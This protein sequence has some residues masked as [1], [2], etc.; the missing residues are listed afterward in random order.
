MLD[1]MI[2]CWNNA[3]GSSDYHWSVWQDGRRLEMGG[4]F[5]RA[6]DA[7]SAARAHCQAAF[8]RQPDRVRQL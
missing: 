7:E 5:E 8:G 6:E 2:E 4:R 1:V 3:D